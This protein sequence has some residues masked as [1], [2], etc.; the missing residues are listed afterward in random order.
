VYLDAI[1][2]TAD[3]AAKLIGQL[4]AFARRQTLEPEIFEVAQRLDAIADM[5]DS[6]TGTRVLVRFEMPETTLVAR[7]SRPGS[8]RIWTAKVASCWSSKII[9]ASASSR[10]SFATILAIAP[11]G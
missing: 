1:G 2:D 9:L 5:L 10:P 4:L 6:I 8:S 11:S 3:R 7:Q